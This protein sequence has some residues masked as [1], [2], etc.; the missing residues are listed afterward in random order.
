[1]CIQNLD[2]KSPTKTLLPMITGSIISQA[3]YVAA[4]LRIADLLSDGPKSCDELA[5][6]V[7]V[8]SPTL[9]RV[10]RALASL[11]IFAE[12]K[13]SHFELTPLAEPLQSDVPGSLRAAAILYGEEW[14]WR[15]FG[16]LLYSVET[17]KPAFDQI[18]GM[19]VY[20]YF[21]KNP[22]STAIYYEAMSAGASQRS[23]DVMAAYDFSAIE[24]IVD[25]GGGYGSLTAAILKAYP[26]MRGVVYDLPHATETAKRVI[27]E[28]GVADRC[29]VVSGDFFKGV[30]GGG[31]A[32][33][34]ERIVHDWDDDHAI[35]I[36]R[37]CRGAMDGGGKLVVIERII[38]P[39]PQSSL[40]KLADVATSSIAT[41]RMRTQAEHRALLTD[42]GLMVTNVIP[43]KSPFTIIEAAPRV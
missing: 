38:S 37:N 1:M 19:D 25:V 42:A 15:P 33:I 36:L 21:G 43:T 3:I 26:G 5:A 30:P 23:A 7:G 22:E 9:Y 18:F 27:V 28:E 34:L 4:K 14:W 11:E 10:L 41:G 12:V 39:G 35:A 17:G 31:D 40:S 32:Y 29:E 16:E 24:R 6:S 2:Q 20:E 13:D 8:H